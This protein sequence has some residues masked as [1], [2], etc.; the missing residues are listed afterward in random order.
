M[1]DDSPLLTI[2][3][4][5]SSLQR[6]TGSRGCH[7]EY[8]FPSVPTTLTPLLGVDLTLEYEGQTPGFPF[9]ENG[10]SKEQLVNGCPD[11]QRIL[12]RAS[13]EQSQTV[14]LLYL[15]CLLQSMSGGHRLLTSL[16]ALA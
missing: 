6:E 11:L 8:G 10:F 14:L 16:E 9:L 5:A 12:Y 1:V 2:P 3:L 15:I 7:L 4:L 13:S